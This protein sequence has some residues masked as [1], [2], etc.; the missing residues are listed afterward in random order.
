MGTKSSPSCYHGALDY[1]SQI[2]GLS[3]RKEIL[4]YKHEHL[5]TK[6]NSKGKTKLKYYSYDIRVETACGKTVSYFPM[7]NIRF[8]SLYEAKRFIVTVNRHI[9]EFGLDFVNVG[10]YKDSLGGGWHSM[11]NLY[12]HNNFYYADM[13]CAH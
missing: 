13:E 3:V 8:D 5:R 6:P 11:V 7:P 2:T 9:D 4:L 1:A 12:K 10:K